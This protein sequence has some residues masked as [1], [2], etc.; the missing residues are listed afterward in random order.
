MWK[1]LKD[2]KIFA[3]IVIV[4]VFIIFFFSYINSYKPVDSFRGIGILGYAEDSEPYIK[5]QIYPD[6]ITEEQ[7]K[8]I[9]TTASSKFEEST[10]LGG[11]VKTIRKS[12][13]GWID[14]NDP[15]I[16]PIIE[17]VCAIEKLPFENAEDLQV[18]EYEPNGFYNEHHDSC[19]D[20]DKTCKT[21]IK[22][23]GHRVATML[24]YLTDDFE[25][26]GTSFPKLRLKLK[27]K[28][29]SGILFHPL[30]ESREKCHPHALHAGLPVKSGKKYVANVWLRQREFNL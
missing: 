16:K 24:I 12:K 2:R 21:F 4:L 1:I 27:P 14:R 15:N 29:Y 20:D 9:I 17:K 22:D 13:T 25:G 28:K 26:G 10:I 6:F 8:Y 5:P 7:A 11:F 23:G 30:E 18:V 3:A 19:C